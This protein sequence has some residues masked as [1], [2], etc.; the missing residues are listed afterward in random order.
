MSKAKKIFRICLIVVVGLL[1]VYLLMCSY[2]V[3]KVKSYTKTSYGLYPYE[4]NGFVYEDDYYRLSPYILINRTILDGKMNMQYNDNSNSTGEILSET[5]HVSY[6][7][8]GLSYAYFDFSEGGFVV[9]TPFDFEATYENDIGHGEVSGHCN[10]RV[11]INMRNG[12]WRI[13]DIKSD[14]EV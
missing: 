3:S 12:S 8:S 2:F 13:S 11:T 9:F 5:K 6:E 14:Y 10:R 7:W 1:V 4:K